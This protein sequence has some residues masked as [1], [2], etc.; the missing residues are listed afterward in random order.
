MGKVQGILLSVPVLKL[1][2]SNVPRIPIIFVNNIIYFSLP[3][4]NDKYLCMYNTAGR[5]EES[6]HCPLPSWSFS[7]ERHMILMISKQSMQD[8]LNAGEGKQR[9]WVIPKPIRTPNIRQTRHGHPPFYIPLYATTTSLPTHPSTHLSFYPSI[10]PSHLPIYSSTH[11]SIH[12]S[13]HSPI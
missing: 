12:P 10:Q 5:G 8:S 9:G 1:T 2:K 11:I 13:I 7:L 3:Y 6:D 4:S